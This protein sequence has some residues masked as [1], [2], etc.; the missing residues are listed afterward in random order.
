MTS[1]Q[2]TCHGPLIVR[3]EANACAAGGVQMC[4]FQ[5]KKFLDLG[6]IEK[7]TKIGQTKSAS[8]GD[9]LDKTSGDQIKLSPELEKAKVARAKRELL[10]S[11]TEKHEA[12]AAA[13]KEL[14][15]VNT[16]LT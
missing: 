14:L 4:W 2:T 6:C 7:K 12:H 16:K 3:H 13:E 8:A 9:S 15:E 5:Q 10:E 1:S 11:R